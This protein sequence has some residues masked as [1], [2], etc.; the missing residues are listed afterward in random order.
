MLGDI[1]GRFCIMQLPCV[2]Y[3]LTASAFEVYHSITSMFDKMIATTLTCFVFQ[4]VLPVPLLLAE[5]FEGDY[6]K[7]E[8]PKMSEMSNE[9]MELKLHIAHVFFFFFFCM[10][11]FG[12]FSL[13]FFNC[14]I[15]DFSET[16]GSSSQILKV[17]S[18][19]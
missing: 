1:S 2:L 6:L 4:C 8:S 15:P 18:D 13:L 14:Y 9:F 7:E 19:L 5:D 12:L 3:K 16:T 10:W 11:W 17:W